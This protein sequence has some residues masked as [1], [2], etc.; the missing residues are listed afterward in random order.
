MRW[1]TR[2]TR[3]PSWNGPP[4]SRSLPRHWLRRWWPASHRDGIVT[5]DAALL[6]AEISVLTAAA[7][8]FFT[9]DTFDSAVAEIV[10]PHTAALNAHAQHGDPRVIE[11]IRKCADLADDLGV[12]VDGPVGAGRRDDYA[13]AAGA[14]SGKSGPGTVARGVGTV[15]WS[16]VPAGVFDAS[17]DTVDWRVELA[18]TAVNAVVQVELTGSSSP[19]GIAVRLRSDA[20]DG[21]GVL[22]ADGRAAFAI[23]DAH[24]RPITESAAWEHDWRT[25]TVTIGADVEESA[26][27]RQRVRDFARSRLAQLAAD[28]YLAEIL[29]AKSDY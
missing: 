27:I 3:K 28:A 21:A 4:N 14:D 15:N 1:P 5:L 12:A 26:Q 24:Q 10:R 2:R 22:G 16:A 6:D 9:D 18:G 25:A 7:Q 8:E 17:E 13:L 19:N 23:V 29:A 20:I 11:L